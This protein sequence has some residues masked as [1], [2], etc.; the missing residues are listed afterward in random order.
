MRRRLI[1]YRHLGASP[2][3]SLPFSPEGFI[4]EELSG[5]I[6]WDLFNPFVARVPAE[7]CRYFVNR[8]LSKYQLKKVLHLL[9]RTN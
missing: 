9:Q 4:M 5:E 2:F 1:R 8:D 3:L 6:H 7:M